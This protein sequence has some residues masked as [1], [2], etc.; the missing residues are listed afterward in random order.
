MLLNC[1]SFL[2]GD[3]AKKTFF[4]TNEFDG[5][6]LTY[7]GRYPPVICKI[8]RVINNI[9]PHRRELEIWNALLNVENILWLL[10]MLIFRTDFIQI[11]YQSGQNYTDISPTYYFVFETPFIIIIIIIIIVYFIVKVV[12]LFH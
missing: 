6:L 4:N 10:F 12:F 11:S 7:W 1:V 2:F 5:Y 8:E 3:N 9:L